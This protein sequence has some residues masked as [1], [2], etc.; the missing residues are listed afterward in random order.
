MHSGK[1]LVAD[2]IAIA[3]AI[4]GSTLVAINIGHNQLGYASYF[5]SGCA[6]MYLL[7]DTE[8][9]KSIKF[10]TLFFMVINVVGMCRY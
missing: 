7:K 10:I 4:T 3:G 1:K 6:T 9:S 5:I 2:V 8:V